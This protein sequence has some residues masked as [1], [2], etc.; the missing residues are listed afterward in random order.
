MPRFDAWLAGGGVAADEQATSASKQAS[1]T[2]A[3]MSYG[4]DK[5]KG[6]EDDIASWRPRR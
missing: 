5:K 1:G 2:F 4:P 3:A 6:T